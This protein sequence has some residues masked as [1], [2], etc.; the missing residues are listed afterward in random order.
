MSSVTHFKIE[1]VRYKNMVDF[2]Y[3]KIAEKDEL[4][5][6]FSKN[7]NSLMVKQNRYHTTLCRK[8][9][10]LCFWN[11]I[12]HFRHD[13]KLSRKHV[14]GVFGNNDR[15]YGKQS[16]KCGICRTNYWIIK[17]CKSYTKWPNATSACPNLVALNIF[18]WNYWFLNLQPL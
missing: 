1:L 10:L 13:A 16:K 9:V 2:S 3:M 4:Y 12:Q 15:I 5:L 6:M 8:P 17:R 18:W 7:R 14:F 11:H